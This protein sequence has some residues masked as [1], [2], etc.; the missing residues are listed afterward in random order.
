MFKRLVDLTGYEI[1]GIATTV[2]FFIAF[3]AI[4][5]RVYF[6]RA[7]YIEEMGHLPLDD[8]SNTTEQNENVKD[9]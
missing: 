7:T 9:Q 4:L 1:A 2:A 3:I 8:A 5:V 6:L